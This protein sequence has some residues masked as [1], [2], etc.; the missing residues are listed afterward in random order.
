MLIE[1]VWSN[2]GIMINSVCGLSQR[3][4]YTDRVTAADPWVEGVAWSAWRIPTAV[5]SVFYEARAGPIAHA[6]IAS[7][8]NLIELGWV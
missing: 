5:I 6:C 3:A 2:A 8:H 4:N 1:Q 7:L